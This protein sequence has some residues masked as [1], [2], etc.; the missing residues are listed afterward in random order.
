MQPGDRISAGTCL[1]CDNPAREVLA[2]GGRDDRHLTT[3]VCL[4]CGMVSHHPLPDPV[5]LA[6]YYEREYRLAHKGTAQPKPKHVLR[7][8]RGAIAR[9]RRLAPL[10]PPSARVLDIGASSGEFTHVMTCLGFQATGMEPNLGYAAFA[11]N[12]LGAAVHDGGYEAAPAVPGG[13]HLITLNHVLEHLPDPAE[14]LSRFHTLLAP[15]GFLFL[16]VPNLL[17]VR[18]RAA[19]LFHIAHVWNF[20]PETLTGLAARHGFAVLP[21][22]NTADTSLVFRR[23]P[24]AV[25]LPPDPDL[26]ARLRRQV[27]V[28]QAN[29]AY[30]LSGAPFLRRW[31]RLCRTLDEWRTVRR[32]ATTRALADALIA[33]SFGES[34]AYPRHA[35]HT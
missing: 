17:G 11:R 8:L 7:A 10:L 1:V 27:A 33:T 26:A 5:R 13:Y 31:H 19:N 6:A 18:K 30:L 29:L 25:A 12:A 15:D 3:V 22:E 23:L 34:A 35:G 32:F 9:A 28:E 4:G 21:G 24:A 16:E 2:R 20:T 14:A